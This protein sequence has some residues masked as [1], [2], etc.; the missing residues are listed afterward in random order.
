LTGVLEAY[1]AWGKAPVGE[2]REWVYH[3]TT[4]GALLAG[5]AAPASDGA[6]GGRG[7]LLALLVGAGV[8]TWY[9]L[10]QRPPPD[11]KPAIAVLPLD[12]MGGGDSSAR[13]TQGITIHDGVPYET[14]MRSM[15]A[16]AGRAV[17]DSLMESRI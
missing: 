14:V 3:R 11:G 5:A 12:D 10:Q 8:A 6:A 7:L 9:G 2:Q 17:T 1:A 4:A 13:L 16:D 15:K